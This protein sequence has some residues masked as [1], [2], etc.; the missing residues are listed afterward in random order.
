MRRAVLILTVCL[1]SIS[2][3]TAA[4]DVVF[5]Y[6]YD[7]N[8]NGFFDTSTADGLAA[9]DR[10]DDVASY[11]EGILNDTLL[12]I[13][14]SGVNT[15]TPQFSN[16]ATGL[17]ISGEIDMNVAADTL[18]VYAGGRDMGALGQGGAGG[19]SAV[20]TAAWLDLVASRGENPIT[21]FGPWGGSVSFN[22]NLPT[23]YSW[24]FSA[25]D[26]ES[27]EYDFLSVAIHEMGH[28]LGIGGATPW[29]NYIS[30]SDFTGP[31]ARA[32]YGDDVP[33]NDNAHW[34][35]GTKSEVDGVDQEAA[36]DPTIAN[37]KRKYFTD[38]DEAGLSDIGWEIVPEPA[39]L[40]LL[41]G[42]GI[43]L[44]LKQQRRRKTA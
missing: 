4:I 35:E 26:P 8:A 5:D 6:Y 7:D 23:D 21:D 32:E 44:L 30:G 3:A 27:D 25:N 11:Y 20:G 43:G 24:N 15:W 37:G 9:R 41:V 39:T 34:K 14:P 42:G 29:Q 38:L 1:I 40:C 18:I 16:P 22:T 19:Y 2:P 10:M 36:M 28:V 12:A 31:A 17:P 13:T 33:L